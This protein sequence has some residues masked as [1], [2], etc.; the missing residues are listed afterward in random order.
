MLVK[1][2]NDAIDGLKRMTHRQPKLPLALRIIA[3]GCVVLWLAGV[4]ACS[5]EALFCCES[6][7]DEAGTH[8]D[9]Q[10]THDAELADARGHHEHDAEGHDSRDAETHHSH[11]AESRHA[12]DTETHQ[13]SNGS[14]KHDGKDGSCCTTLKAIAQT[15][16]PIV[17]TKPNLQPVAFLCVLLQARITALNAPDN[18][19]DRPPHRRE[20]V[21]TPEVCT[22]PANR[23]HA[24]PTSI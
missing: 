6:H 15:A 8:A 5:L 24:P 2:V 3:A 19:S 9:H 16:K 14:H 7:G 21:S 11:D 10:H 22:G 1:R 18:F 4:S 17:I 20:W 23:A 13:G 12:H